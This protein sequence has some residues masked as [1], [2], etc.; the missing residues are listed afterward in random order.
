MLFEGVSLQGLQLPTE[1]SHIPMVIISLCRDQ[2]REN[3]KEKDLDHIIMNNRVSYSDVF[4]NPS[5][6]E[7]PNVV[8]L[9]SCN[10]GDVLL[11]SHSDHIRRGSL[12]HR[13]YGKGSRSPERDC[14][15]YQSRRSSSGL[16]RQDHKPLKSFRVS[17]D[18]LKTWP[19]Q[20]GENTVTFI[21]EADKRMKV[22]CKVYPSLP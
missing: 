8:S 3:M 21:P 4:E 9:P 6:L 18:V 19:L 12:P 10:V 20:D 22:T 5:L 14:F 17:S 15:T 16:P 2:Y 11:R 1:E 7:H 13:R